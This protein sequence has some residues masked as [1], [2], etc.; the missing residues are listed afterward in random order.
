MKGTWVRV[1]TVQLSQIMMQL[2]YFDYLNIIFYH[3]NFKY[4][5]HVVKG[6]EVCHNTQFRDEYNLI[7]VQGSCM[8]YSIAAEREDVIM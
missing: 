7:P 4:K 5:I 3:F 1:Y 6:S 8:M 2:M